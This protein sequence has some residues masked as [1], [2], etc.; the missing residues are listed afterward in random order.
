[1]IMNWLQKMMYGRYGTDQL[2]IALLIFS[3]LLTLVIQ[4][5]GIPWLSL[6]P[7]CL[8]IICFVRMFSRNIPRR[9][10]ENNQFL[11]LWNPVKSWFS[12]QRRKWKDRKTHRYYKCPKCS[13][14]LRV[15]KGKGKICITCP[16]CR[17]EIIR[18]T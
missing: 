15:P 8:L 13:R 7:L 10:Q 12:L 9:Y 4:L 18:K 1:M 5:I 17:T 11:K 14:I 6:L 2:N 16:G 3:M